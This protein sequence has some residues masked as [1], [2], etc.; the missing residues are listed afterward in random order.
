[1][2][3]YLETVQEQKSRDSNLKQ[4]DMPIREYNQKFIQLERLAPEL[5]ATE[6]TK[7]SKF[8]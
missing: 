6:R 4:E 2:T 5:C 8:V 7:T 3:Y 1:M